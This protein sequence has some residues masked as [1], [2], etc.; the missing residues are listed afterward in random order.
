MAKRN[1]DIVIQGRYDGRHAFQEAR[2]DVQSWLAQVRESRQQLNPFGNLM[3][4]AERTDTRAA[5]AKAA[6][7]ESVRAQM[8]MADE[9]NSANAAARTQW[10]AEEQAAI[11]AD[12]TA[13]E[14]SVRAQMRM[15]E[16]LNAANAAARTQWL[17]EEQAAIKADVTAQEE[18]VRAQMRMAEELNA[19]N[20]AART[21][22][23]AEEQAAIKADVTAQWQASQEKV[24]ISMR[25][26][27]QRVTLEDQLYAA[28]HSRREVELNQLQTYYAR[29]RAQ[30]AGNAKMLTLIDKAYAAQSAQIMTATAGGAGGRGGISGVFGKNARY[31]ASHAGMQ[32]GGEIGMTLSNLVAFGAKGAAISGGIMLISGAY[33]T[34]TKHAEQLVEKQKAYRDF[35]RDSVEWM[36]KLSS[37][38]TTSTGAEFQDRADQLAEQ[39]RT[40]ERTSVEESRK[41]GLFESGMIMIEA[42]L[43][44]GYGETQY[45]QGVSEQVKLFR[46]LLELSKEY[47]ISRKHQDN[48][49]R[50]IRDENMDAAIESARIAAMEEGP[51]K[52]RLSLLQSQADARRK[53]GYEHTERRLR[54]KSDTSEGHE[55]RMEKELA[56]QRDEEQK[57][58]VRQNYEYNAV[59]RQNLR[60]RADEER[61]HYRNLRSM[62]YE[63]ASET[64]HANLRGTAADKADLA[65]ARQKALEEAKTDEERILIRQTFRQR[66]KQQE[67]NQQDRDRELLSQA[68]EARLNLI[69]DAGQKEI[70]LMLWRQ[71]EERR[72][73]KDNG[74]NMSLL[75]YRQAAERE[76]IQKPASNAAVDTGFLTR[77]PREFLGQSERD[78]QRQI[79]QNTKI[80]NAALKDVISVLKDIA[81]KGGGT[82]AEL[83]ADYAGTE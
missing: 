68:V 56:R 48:I 12:V 69:E 19:A 16:E 6:Q 1:I 72:I 71:N 17:A 28:T 38:Y 76:Q 14:E 45:G 82:T 4:T 81:A 50:Q 9:L 8:R 37:A 30:H 67:R 77:A 13:Q 78:Q 83:V 29:M 3:A 43:R 73:A 59:D 61:E 35:L 66:E 42:V 40:L 41:L 65:L 70:A 47:S 60:E 24:S 18:S 79:A 26:Y 74:D 11:K 58:M 53:L 44:G 63:L 25:E 51:E 23:L 80:T 5:A 39:A 64:I 22:W 49:E 7:E 36:K 32:I 21:Q 27:R 55:F 46:E 34:I 31:L 20:A 10:L 62:Q 52:R 75:L 33:S 15:A 57:L 2:S 54:F